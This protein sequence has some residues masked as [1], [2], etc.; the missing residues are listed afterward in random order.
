MACPSYSRK[1]YSHYQRGNYAG[2]ANSTSIT[3]GH[4]KF[5]QGCE[6]QQQ[7]K[8][9]TETRDNI[10]ELSHFV[11]QYYRLPEEPLQSRSRDWLI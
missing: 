1:L 7:Q 9:N 4:Q 5:N 3:S 8:R 6:E 11:D 10:K 2:K